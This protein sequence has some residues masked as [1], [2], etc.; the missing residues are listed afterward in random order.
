MFTVI[1]TDRHTGES[2]RHFLE[3]IRN[4]GYSKRDVFGEPGGP[5]LGT[6]TPNRRRHLEQLLEHIPDDACELA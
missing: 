3:V 6:A 1:F 4:H 2:L 5:L